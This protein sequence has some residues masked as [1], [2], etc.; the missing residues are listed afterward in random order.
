[1]T[2]KQQLIAAVLLFLA[3]LWGTAYVIGH[4]PTGHWA[5]FPTFITGA[6]GLLLALVWAVAAA[7]LIADE[8]DE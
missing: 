3:M 6:I 4:I 7:S 2:S 5:A 1:M 8:R